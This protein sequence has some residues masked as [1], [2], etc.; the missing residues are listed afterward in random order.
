MSHDYVAIL[1]SVDAAVLLVATLQYGAL[2]RSM[3]SDREASV[4]K[5]Q[6][7]MA[8]IIEARR[9]G[10]QPSN[11]DL[12]ELQQQHVFRRSR[13]S[14]AASLPYLLGSVVYV[15]LCGVLSSSILSIIKW[16]GTADPGPDP[17][18]AR[19][20]FYITAG[21]VSALLVEAYS[22]GIV[23]AVRTRK[24]LRRRLRDA[25]GDQEVDEVAA[26][27]N[28]AQPAPAGTPAAPPGAAPSTPS[29]GATP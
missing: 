23:A 13:L 3:V 6:D 2:L 14:T 27:I 4:K 26:L 19:R 16:A 28:A 25:Y 18:L 17:E 21:A 8:L 7:Q 11:A 1:I 20:A 12:L 29:G 24:A 5:R 10:V 22:A 15:T 9:N